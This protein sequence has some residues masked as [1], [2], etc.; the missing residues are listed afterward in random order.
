MDDCILSV[1]INFLITLLDDSLVNQ[2]IIFPTGGFIK[3]GRQMEYRA[4]HVS[5]KYIDD[6]EGENFTGS[7]LPP[8]DCEHLEDSIRA[9]LIVEI[10]HNMGKERQ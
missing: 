3:G 7:D 8:T 2:L 5:G 6:D 1:S 9:R 10:F 4:N